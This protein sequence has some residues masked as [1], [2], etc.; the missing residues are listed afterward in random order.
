VIRGEIEQTRSDMG[1]TIDA[2]G[3]KADVPGRT[4][5]W[6][7]DK[8][9]TIVSGVS[10]RKD[11]VVSRVGGMTPDGEAVKR[12]SLR[13]KDTAEQNPLGL[14]IGGAAIGFIAGLFAP[15]TRVE[16]EKLGPIADQVKSSAVE[17]GQEALEHGK[18]V[19]QSAAE[20]AVET[21]K[22]EGRAHGD[23]LTSSLQ[24]KAREVTQTGS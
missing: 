2:L 11:A 23:E 19:A 7:A 22:E 6:V 21:A 5:G 17:A 3:Y 1:E 12:R 9:D 20:S 4:K 13:L 15:S 10:G 14:A 24:D 18:Q 16:D 8:K